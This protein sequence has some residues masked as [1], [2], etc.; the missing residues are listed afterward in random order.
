MKLLSVL[1]IFILLIFIVIKKRFYVN[2][3]VK[4]AI[5]LLGLAIGCNGV[6]LIKIGKYFNEHDIIVYAKDSKKE[7]NLVELD[8]EELAVYLTLYDLKGKVISTTMPEREVDESYQFSGNSPPKTR[9]DINDNLV[10]SYDINNFFNEDGK[11]LISEDVIYYTDIPSYIIPSEDVVVGTEHGPNG[12]VRLYKAGNVECFGGIYM[13]GKT[14]YRLKFRFEKTTNQT[15]IKFNFQLTFNLSNTIKNQATDLKTIDFET[16]GILQFWLKGEEIKEPDENKIYTLTETTKDVRTSGVIKDFV[17]S[18]VDHRSEG[19]REL[20]GVLKVDLSDGVGLSTDWSNWLKNVVI[21]AD[22]HKIPFLYASSSG[23]YYATDGEN[24]DIIVNFDEY[25]QNIDYGRNWPTGS[26]T[27]CS[28][29]RYEYSCFIKSL[30]IHFGDAFGNDVSLK[31]VKEWQVVISEKIFNEESTILNYVT[32]SDLTKQVEDITSLT[33]TGNGTCRYCGEVNYNSTSYIRTSTSEFNVNYNWN[34]SGNYVQMNFDTSFHTSSGLYYYLSSKVLGGSDKLEDSMKVYVD[35]SLVEFVRNGYFIPSIVNGHSDVADPALQ[36]QMKR[37]FK[38]KYDEYFNHYPYCGY[39]E[40]SK[41]NE[42]VSINKNASV[43]RSKT[44]NEN[45]EYYWLIFDM[46]TVYDAYKYGFTATG[47]EEFSMYNCTSKA[48]SSSCRAPFKYTNNLNSDETLKIRMYLFNISKRNVKVSVPYKL[49]YSNRLALDNWNYNKDNPYSDNSSLH[50]CF[51]GDYTECNSY[52]TYN[53]ANSDGNKYMSIQ[54]EKM[55]DD[56]TKWEV[57]INTSELEYFYKIQNSSYNSNWYLT[58][59]YLSLPSELGFMYKDSGVSTNNMGYFYDTNSRT[60]KRGYASSKGDKVWMAG[61]LL[62]ACTDANCDSVSQSALSGFDYYTPAYDGYEDYNMLT[63]QYVPN[64][65]SSNQLYYIKISNLVR[66]IHDNQLRLIFFTKT[67]ENNSNGSNSDDNHQIYFQFSTGGG[68]VFSRDNYD[69]TGGATV[70]IN[71]VG[72]GVALNNDTINKDRE[73][74]PSLETENKNVIKWT[75]RPRAISSSSNYTVNSRYAVPTSSYSPTSFSGTYQFSEKFSGIP[76]DYTKL[77]SIKVSGYNRKERLYGS[78]YTSFYNFDLAFDED[79]LI[80]F[81]NEGVTLAEKCDS[82]GVCINISYNIDEQCAMYEDCLV[83][84][85]GDDYRE[86]VRL[87]ANGFNVSISGL[88]DATDLYIEY[89]SETDNKVMYDDLRKNDKL[90]LLDDDATF[91]LK[92]ETTSFDW[93]SQSDYYT[94]KRD[95]TT[96][97]LEYKTRLMADVFAKKA[98]EEISE[99]IDSGRYYLSRDNTRNTVFARIG[100]FPS[101]Y[102]EIKDIMLGAEQYSNR[103]N[104]DLDAYLLDDNNKKALLYLKQYLEFKNFKISYCEKFNNTDDDCVDENVIYENGKFVEGWSKSKISFDKDLLNLYELHLEKDDGK[105]DDTTGYKVTYDL[106]FDIDNKRQV[107]D[108]N[109]NILSSFRESEYFKGTYLAIISTVG[110][111]RTYETDLTDEVIEKKDED[112]TNSNRHQELMD[113]YQSEIDTVKKTLTAYAKSEVQ[114]GYLKKPLIYKNNS[115]LDKNINLF[116]WNITYNAYSTGKGKKAEF[117]VG[118]TYYIALAD[119]YKNE[120]FDSKTEEKIKKL[121]ELLLEYSN[122]KNFTLE[123]KDNI[124][125]DINFKKIHEIDEKLENDKEYSY[126][127]TDGKTITL[128]LTNGSTTIESEKIKT[129]G[130]TYKVDNLSYDSSIKLN[131]NIEVDF[132]EFYL[133]AFKEGLIDENCNIKGTDK[134]YIAVIKNIVSNLNTK[135]SL[136]KESTSGYL[137]LENYK[138]KLTKTIIEQENDRMKWQLKFNT[139]TSNKEIDIEDQLTITGNEVI[140]EA[141]RIN[142]VTISIGSEI[143]YENGQ[144]VAGYEDNILVSLDK[145]LLHVKL[146]PS[147]TNEFL[148]DNKVVT[149]TYDSFIDSEIYDSLNGIKNGS[150]VLENDATLKKGAIVTKDK[151]KTEEINFDFPLTINKTYLGNPDEDLTKTKWNI[152]VNTGALKRKDVYITDISSVN[153]EY[154]KYLR[155]TDLVITTTKNDKKEILYDSRIDKELPSNIKIFDLNN[156]EFK[157]LQNGNYNF[158][159][160]FKEIDNLTEISIDYTLAIDKEKYEYEKAVPDK[161]IRIENV[162]KVKSD[163][164]SGDE[165]SSQGDMLYPSS[166]KKTYKNNGKSKNNLPLITWY[167]DVNLA[168]DYGQTLGKDDEVILTDQLDDILRYYNDSLKIYSLNVTP[169]KIEIAKEEWILGEDY[170]FTYE[171][172]IIRLKILKPGEKNNFRVVFDTE[173]LMSATSFKNYVSLSVNGKKTVASSSLPN[174]FNGVFG[175]TITSQGITYYSFYVK[176]YLDGEISNVPFKFKLESVNSENER[177]EGTEELIVDSDEIGNAI[178]GPITYKKDGIYYYRIT[179]IDEGGNY[180]YDKNSYTIKVKVIDYKYNYVIDEVTI[181]NSDSNEINFYNTTK[182]DLDNPNTSNN[183]K[184]IIIAIIVSIIVFIKTFK[185]KR[186]FN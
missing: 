129:K 62:Y 57:N 25:Y 177:I 134:P 15:D 35:N 67:K 18:I 153:E 116:N 42:C 34:S 108:E 145:I 119:I 103:N 162:A 168:V 172:N 117:N 178:L 11:L 53:F 65:N 29:G 96:S 124:Y 152:K 45:G 182:K 20:K 170:L 160:Y 146:K 74:I 93:H 30:S 13:E 16:F 122:Y 95:L 183:L 131:Y 1:L 43:W 14:G 84:K 185:Y 140:K 72:K 137:S 133:A 82:N 39:N 70:N 56:I 79:D 165:S 94:S 88:L 157:L 128:K 73:E 126:F 106:V 110:A 186:K 46:K 58:Y 149:I 136:N 66:Y 125:R 64:Y 142:N 127:L 154:Q 8:T 38:D 109:G 6:N 89:V 159:V 41:Y 184:L 163:N 10:L 130:F 85:Y 4:I 139:G 166:L 167:V 48:S 141:M 52:N 150:F 107:T 63:S 148:S 83:G 91:N 59:F 176:K 179:E 132:E 123:Y 100:Y 9:I 86:K 33:G 36:L 47:R 105:L 77:K 92:S 7:D 97:T 158:I 3:G 171:D 55:I 135:D 104:I 19:E 60:V 24:I 69:G 164:I 37:V 49:G 2:K 76:A 27:Q 61:N 17:T 81:V 23:G 181:I 50:Y 112:S 40:I 28:D 169:T 80:K 161:N 90:G 143:I 111:T 54:S 71:Y 101:K 147:S 98:T 21:Y 121:N 78:S 174:I 155:I 113:K 120:V 12:E 68:T 118:D 99:T 87:L 144:A 102:L 115:V 32:Y 180:N 138:T 156:K 31:G 5:L 175:G 151:V 26:D 114:S 44:T 75:I 51:R 173:V 22:G